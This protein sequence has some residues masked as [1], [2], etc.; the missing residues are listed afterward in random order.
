MARTISLMSEIERNA[1]RRV[2]QHLIRSNKIAADPFL[3]PVPK[4]V[5]GY[6]EMIKEPID[7]TSIRQKLDANAY[8][9]RGELES[10]FFLMLFNAYTFNHP[11]NPVHQYATELEN[12]F[13]DL[14]RR[15]IGDINDQL[16]TTALRKVNDTLEER[17]KSRQLLKRQRKSGS[18]PYDIERKLDLLERQLGRA[19]STQAA[20]LDPL[21]DRQKLAVISS[22]EQLDGQYFTKL[23]HL[24]ENEPAASFGPD[25]SLELELDQLTATKQHEL[26]QFVETIR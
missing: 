15:A 23:K 5:P 10:D 25:N 16:V 19:P 8:K 1:Y 2:I 14:M 22:L 21:N 12:S 4:S 6:H 7:L 17:R 20:Q 11:M 26:L 18:A 24:L 3:N 13:R 9:S